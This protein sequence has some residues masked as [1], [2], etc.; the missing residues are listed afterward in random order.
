MKKILL[1]AF[2]LILSISALNA[3]K[4]KY[5][6]PELSDSYKKKADEWVL[7]IKNGHLI[8]ENLSDNF[9]MHQLCYLRD[10]TSKEVVEKAIFL[11]L[12]D[13]VKTYRQH[14]INT[15]FVYCCKMQWLDGLKRI[16]KNFNDKAWT[17]F[18]KDL[19]KKILLK[20]L[21][22][23]YLT[24]ALDTNFIEGAEFIFDFLFNVKDNKSKLIFRDHKSKFLTFKQ[25]MSFATKYDEFI[26]TLLEKKYSQKKPVKGPLSDN[27]HWI[28]TEANGW[29]EDL[30]VEATP[31]CNLIKYL[32]RELLLAGKGYVVSEISKKA[33]AAQAKKAIEQ[34][35]SD[36]N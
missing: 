1:G 14:E 18:K 30:V 32:V 21:F 5:G 20:D 34:A 3:G 22:E 36:T 6:L 9:T 23:E 12:K 13:M 10:V 4:V 8:P 15:L 25:K 35:S 27:K 24:K 11:R 17:L 7:P 16:Y 31:D 33:E 29:L 26:R 2:A 28:G 19:W